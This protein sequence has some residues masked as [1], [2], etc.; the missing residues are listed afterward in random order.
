MKRLKDILD[1]FLMKPLYY[2]TGSS[3]EDSFPTLGDITEVNGFTYQ[4]MAPGK[5][6]LMKK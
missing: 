5:W 4:W 2:Q 1:G 3:Q 6:E